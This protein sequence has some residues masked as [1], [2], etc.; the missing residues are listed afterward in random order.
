MIK[1]NNTASSYIGLIAIGAINLFER[2][3]FFTLFSVIYIYVKDLIGDNSTNE[4]IYTI[5]FGMSYVPLIITG[6]IGDITKRKPMI[7]IGLISMTIGCMLLSAHI[8]NIILLII[9]LAII[10]L[11]QA[12]YKP[13]FMVIVGNYF[14]GNYNKKY[15]SYITYSI[16]ASIGSL[17]GILLPIIFSEYIGNQ[18]IIIICAVMCIIATVLFFVTSKTFTH[19]F[20]SLKRNKTMPPALNKGSNLLMLLP[21][22]LLAFPLFSISTM[23]GISFNMLKQDI[24][25]GGSSIYEILSNIRPVATII[26]GGVLILIIYSLRK[27]LKP[28]ALISIGLVTIGLGYIIATTGTVVFDNKANL[29]FIA[30]PMILIGLCDILIYPSFDSIIHNCSPIKFRGLFFGIFYTLMALSNALVGV[31]FHLY[32]DLGH[33]TF[34]II[35]I[36]SFLL[37]A[38]IYFILN[39]INNNILK[40]NI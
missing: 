30:I 19:T 17:I 38:A 8:D 40:H 32:W 29:T 39:I 21:T 10:S 33:M 31:F 4:I 16:S 18:G 37:F 1:N 24:V 25:S 6:L 12:I 35:I 2:A 20:D 34:L 5:F 15:I 36:S 3:A 9:I 14:D 11:G 22:L 27:S 26:G 13:N 28:F 23:P 7:I